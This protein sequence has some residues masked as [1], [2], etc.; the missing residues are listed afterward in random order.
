M[1][2][3]SIAESL[4]GPAQ[5]LRA[6]PNSSLIIVNNTRCNI[7]KIHIYA[8]NSMIHMPQNVTDRRDLTLYLT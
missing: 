4:K 3:V 2:L 6:F 7:L 8:P 1:V 5:N